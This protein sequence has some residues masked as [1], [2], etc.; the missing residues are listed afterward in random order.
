MHFLQAAHHDQLFRVLFSGS[1]T[2]F[3]PRPKGCYLQ[4]H[5][6]NLANNIGGGGGGK[7]TMGI[8]EG[9]KLEK[10]ERLV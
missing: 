3:I 4:Q 9:V 6:R 8:Y 5:W 1:F 10:G 7:S 2:R